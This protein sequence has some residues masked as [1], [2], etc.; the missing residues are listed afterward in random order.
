M[1]ATTRG[2]ILRGTT[3]DEFGEQVDGTDPAP[4]LEDFPCSI[5]ERSVDVFDPAEN[6]WRSVRKLTG[7]IPA[8]I[9]TLDGDRLR[10]NRTGLIYI[11]DEDERQPRSISGRASVTLILRRTG[12]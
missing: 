1:L 5:V 2:A 9:A 7:R 10:D 12:S 6:T 4:G 8:N 3:E 11:I